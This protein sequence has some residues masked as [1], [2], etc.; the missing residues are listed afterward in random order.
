MRLSAFLASCLLS[1]SVQAFAD[2][3]DIVPF[4]YD[5]ASVRAVYQLV[6]GDNSDP[7]SV[8]FVQPSVKI[9]NY[10]NLPSAEKKQ[11]DK[12]I[13]SFGHRYLNALLQIEGVYT[14]EAEIYRKLLYALVDP[15]ID[16]GLLS[17]SE[18]AKLKDLRKN[19]SGMSDKGIIGIISRSIKYDELGLDEPCDVSDMIDDDHCVLTDL[20]FGTDAEL[21]SSTDSETGTQLKIEDGFRFALLLEIGADPIQDEQTAKNADPVPMVYYV[22]APHTILYRCSDN[23][24]KHWEKSLFAM[25]KLMPEFLHFDHPHDTSRAAVLGIKSTDSYFWISADDYHDVTGKGKDGICTVKIY[26]EH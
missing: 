24:K 4:L 5:P 25:L 23:L 6:T 17:K 12:A 19:I 22:R 20:V 18:L 21:I 2:S 13:A 8:R 11:I 16:S 26:G 14:S 15:Y 1:F 3:P 7:V 9:W 10:Q